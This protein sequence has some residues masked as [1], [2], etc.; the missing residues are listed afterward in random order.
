MSDPTR[1]A[2]YWLWEEEQEVQRSIER[3]TSEIE[4][5]E[6]QIVKAR[7]RRQSLRLAAVEMRAARGI[8][9]RSG[10]KVE[11]QAGVPVV[12]VASEEQRETP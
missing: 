8:I 1:G 7:D 10:L 4:G 9:E 2:A 6:A 3:L 11:M 12:S 5:L